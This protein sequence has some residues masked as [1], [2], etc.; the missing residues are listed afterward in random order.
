[1]IHLDVDMD[2][3]EGFA[4]EVQATQGQMRAAAR[5]AARTV[6]RWAL[7]QISR[8][9]SSRLGV[10]ARVTKSRTKSRT[11]KSGARVTALLNQLNVAGIAQPYAQGLRVGNQLFPGAFLA[12][13]RYSNR[14]VALQRVGKGRRPL[15]S[16]ALDVFAE[17]KPLI[18]ETWPELNR[19]FVAEYQRE[20]AR[21]T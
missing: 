16:A 19:R 12:R 13:G 21:R 17:G 11:S 14:K 20:L 5:A 10:P 3:L 8:G 15:Q 4:R 7:V 18:D 2:E 1:M 9:L 6:A